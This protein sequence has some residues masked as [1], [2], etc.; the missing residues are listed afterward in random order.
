MKRN[1]RIH[2]P[3]WQHDYHVL[4]DLYRIIKKI[5][6]EIPKGKLLIDYGCGDLPYKQV[7]GQFQNYAAVDIGKNPRASTWIEENQKLPYKDNSADLL[8][9]TQVLEHVRDTDFYMSECQRLVKTKGYL[10]VSTHG[11][12]PYHE[13]P[14]DYH[15]WTRTGLENLLSNYG[16]KIISTTPILTGFALTLQ[17]ELLLFAKIFQKWGIWG[18]PFYFLISLTGNL[19][20]YFL[21]LLFYDKHA[22]DASV[23]VVL[24]QKI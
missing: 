15:R 5:S 21:N 18:K 3:I 1:K 10:L 14:Y 6:E 8:L 2:P 19:L 7:F 4:T 13:F 12:W 11:V 20:L 22:F 23:F 9:S 16:F 17:F 24:A